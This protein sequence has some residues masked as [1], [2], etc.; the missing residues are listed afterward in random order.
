MMNALAQLNSVHI[1]VN[2]K[3]ASLVFSAIQSPEKANFL[4]CLNKR[5]MYY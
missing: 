2:P 4:S 1:W 5:K 3:S